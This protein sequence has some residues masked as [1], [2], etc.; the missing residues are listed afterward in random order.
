MST[1]TLAR[2]ATNGDDRVLLRGARARLIGTTKNE[3]ISSGLDSNGSEYMIKPV[4]RA[5][6]GSALRI[7]YVGKLST[8]NDFVVDVCSCLG[9]TLNK[10]DARMNLVPPGLWFRFLFVHTTTLTKPRNMQHSDQCEHDHAHRRRF[11][12]TDSCR[13]LKGRTG[14][15]NERFPTSSIHWY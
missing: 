8:K 14:Y 15:F 12:T 7:Q 4:N 5:L 1:T 6:Y 13:V 3:S 10:R 11:Q 2:M 9:S